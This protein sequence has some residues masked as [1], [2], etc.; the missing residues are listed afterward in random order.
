M[1]AT[2]LAKA[3]MRAWESK[4]VN[5]L[6][7]PPSEDFVGTGLLPQR[8]HKAGYIDFMQAKVF[9]SPVLVEGQRPTAGAQR[10]GQ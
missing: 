9:S 3:A 8:A 10:A 7:A 2:D 6:A 1:P 4:D 5:G